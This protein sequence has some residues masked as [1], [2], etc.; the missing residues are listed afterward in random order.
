ML[1]AVQ[2]PIYEATFP[3]NGKK[4]QYRPFLVKE[5]KL[6]LLVKEAKNI[7]DIVK[8]I[9]QIL[10]NCVLTPFDVDDLAIIDLEYMFVLLRARSQG[11]IIEL[12]MICQN[13]ITEVATGNTQP[14]GT[15]SKMAI[16][17]LDVKIKN[18]EGHSNKIELTDTIGLVMK[19]PT[20]AMSEILDR[21]FT[22]SAEVLDLVVDS[23]DY[24][25]DAETVYHTKNEKRD[26]LVKWFEDNISEAMFDKVK[27]FFD[28]VPRVV[29]EAQFHCDRCGYEEKVE[30][31]G[32]QDFFS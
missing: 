8:T 7:K 25:Y 29:G 13:P 19:Y 32:I 18:T 12:D 1:P 26:D 2:T 14:C 27:V 10:I 20:F 22:N 3:S 17:L 15:T 5:K 23:I 6:F 4:V 16:N 21:E 28:T 24:I 9:K 31:Q 30:L 11:E